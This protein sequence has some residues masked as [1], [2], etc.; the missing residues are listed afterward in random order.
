MASAVPARRV[1]I[2]LHHHP[3]AHVVWSGLL[4][5]APTAMRASVLRRPVRRTPAWASKNCKN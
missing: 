4:L 1:V 3:R 2:L 5:C